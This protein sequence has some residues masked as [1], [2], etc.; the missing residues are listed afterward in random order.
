M[1]LAPL[2]L[3]PACCWGTNILPLGDSITFG[4]GDSCVGSTGGWNC[5]LPPY[6]TPC[7][8]CSGGWRQYLWRMLQQSASAGRLR[9]AEPVQ[10]VGT[11][12]NGPSD[13]DTHHEGHPGW[14]IPQVQ[15]I[16]KQWIATSPDVIL[17]H[18]GTNDMGVGLQTGA[19]AAARMRAFLNH[20]LEALPRAHVLLASV[21]GSV[22][23]YGGLSH[24][25]YN[26]QLPG[27]AADFAARG[28]Q[29]DFVDMA[30]ESGIGAYCDPSNCCPLAIHPNLVGYQKMAG[31]WHAHLE[32]VLARRA[33]GAAGAAG[34][35]NAT[36]A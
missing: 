19:A 2:L 7:S 9:G 14:Q 23:T 22:A 20:T 8:T 27:I 5:D 4:C 28:F 36:A 16:S 21:I 33:A 25:A 24:A 1:R 18:L 11:Q 10:F 12:R 17:L 34:A 13:V 32:K 29:V 30:S 3:L 35:T 6:T 31:V 15:A 26:K